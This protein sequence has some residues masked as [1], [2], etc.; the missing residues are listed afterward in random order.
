MATATAIAPSLSPT[1]QISISKNAWLFNVRLSPTES[2][3]PS[4]GP[5]ATCLRA[6]DDGLL[7]T[8][9]HG[10]DQWTHR[11]TL[12]AFGYVAA[13]K[14]DRKFVSCSTPMGSDGAVR[15]AVIAGWTR[16]L[17][18]LMQAR[19]LDKGMA[20]KNRNTGRVVD[21]VADEYLVTLAKAKGIMG[22]VA[23]ANT[24]FV[25]YGQAGGVTGI[26]V[27]RC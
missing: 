9:A 16:E 17:V 7:W 1:F 8:K 22:M 24:V 4:P 19:P 25:L 10:R 14:V 2:T 6:G 26:T 12:N 21:N 13:S 23:D 15:F 20:V 18:V 3:P 5:L 27:V 11:H